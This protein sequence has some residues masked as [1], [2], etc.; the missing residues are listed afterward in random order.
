MV[1]YKKYGIIQ[2]QMEEQKSVNSVWVKKSCSLK[3]YLMRSYIKKVSNMSLNSDKKF[4]E[5]KRSL[6]NGKIKSLFYFL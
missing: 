1:N 4:I 6:D 5:T 2:R 3:N